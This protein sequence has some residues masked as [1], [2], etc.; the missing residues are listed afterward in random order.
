MV[1]VHRHATLRVDGIGEGNMEGMRKWWAGVIYEAVLVA[2]LMVLIFTGK[3]T[4]AI[5]TGWLAAFGGGFAAY[6]LGNV[7]SKYAPPAP[8]VPPS[9]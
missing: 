1:E 5:F 3:L 8:P 9:Q 2:V 6:V 7:A 4:D